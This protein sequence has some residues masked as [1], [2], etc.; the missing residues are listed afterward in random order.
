MFYVI[1]PFVTYLLTL[2]RIAAELHLKKSRISK[3]RLPPDNCIQASGLVDAP[4]RSLRGDGAVKA[5]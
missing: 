1:Y 4:V 3:S 5:C 2:P